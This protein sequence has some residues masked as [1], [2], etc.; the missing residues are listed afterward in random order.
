MGSP[1][2]RASLDGMEKGATYQEGGRE[3]KQEGEHGASGVVP[4]PLLALPVTLGG[5]GRGANGVRQVSQRQPGL[6]MTHCS[7]LPYIAMYKRGT[8]TQMA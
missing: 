5:R 7:L 3:Y 8:L 4:W 2:T 6:P 1:L